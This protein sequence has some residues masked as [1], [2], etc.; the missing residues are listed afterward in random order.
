VF[1]FGWVV[2]AVSGAGTSRWSVSATANS[3]TPRHRHT[4]RPR[5][6]N[7]DAGTRHNPR[8]HRLCVSSGPALAEPAKRP[9]RR[10]RD[11]DEIDLVRA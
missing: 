5:P 2:A 4:M 6:A 3:R 1:R 10:R 11:A 9:P 7:T 8:A